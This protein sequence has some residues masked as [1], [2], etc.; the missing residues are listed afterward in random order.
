IQ[1]IK[2]AGYAVPQNFGIET[3]PKA[4]MGDFATNVAM[5]IGGRDKIS[6]KRVAKKIIE[7][8]NKEKD[9]T[10][11]DIADPEFINIFINSRIYEQEFNKILSEKENYGR[12]EKKL[13]KVNVEYIS[14][15]PTGPLHAGNARGGPIGEALANLFQFLGYEVVREFYVN[16]MGLQIE[17]FGNSLYYWFA[18]KEDAR[19]EF[20]EDGYPGGYIK[21]ISEIVQK[22][23]KE[24]L[25]K[26]KDKDE[27]IKFFVKEGLYYT[28]KSMR[29]DAKLLGIKF[30]KWAYESDLVFS[31]K[32]NRAIDILKQKDFTTQK[33]G[34]VWFK[35][36]EDRELADKES[37]LIKSDGKSLTYFAN[38]IAYHMDKFERGHDLLIDIWGA[39]HHGHLLRF[40][41][42]MRAVGTPDDKIVILF[43]QYI[44]LKKA[45]KAV[46][47]GKR[48]GNFV[49][50]R[51]VIEAG[52]APD[53][54]KYFILSQN[55]N[56]P[57][58]FDLQSAADTSE[59]NPVYY[60]KYAHARI[61][62]ILKKTKGESAGAKLK[63]A[64]LNHPKEVAL[65]K[66][67]VKF[68]Q[69][70]EQISED[71]QIQTLPHY[72]YKIAGL[73]H[74][75]YASCPVLGSDKKT[76]EARL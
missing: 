26:L 2:G 11:A 7:V 45:G 66:E 65:Y 37:V 51:Q 17:R 8:L 38:D 55:P 67:L 57:F 6:P 31:G 12:G 13:T 5:I 52:V 68:K 42:A 50:L 14:A 15:N 60:I 27:I 18:K 35:N 32:T 40:K 53:A 21:E 72:A 71:F 1:A 73:F 29:E 76:R 70:I 10:K 44:R 4:E 63:I 74:D 20:P 33:E 47:M 46:S 41:A 28:V 75:F 49:T 16:D 23:K 30:D 36:P 62:S 22:E 3:P 25:F 69:I 9:I 61:C 54:F 64:A 34:A 56:T 19:I 43:Y 24:E 39:N 59:K 48:L 58:D